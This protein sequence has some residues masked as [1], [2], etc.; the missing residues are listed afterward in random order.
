MNSPSVRAIRA[1]FPYLPRGAATAIK[2]MMTGDLPEE[3][4]NAYPAAAA[5]IQECYHPPTYNDKALH[6]MD[7]LL[8]TFGVAGACVRNAMYDGMSYCDTGDTYATT[9]VLLSLGGH[10]TWHVCSWGSLVESLEKRGIH[11]S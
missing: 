8:S 1:A 3:A 4:L 5:R 11:F 10:D 9:I 7:S 2:K 6:V